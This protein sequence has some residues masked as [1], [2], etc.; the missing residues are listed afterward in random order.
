VADYLNENYMKNKDIHE[1]LLDEGVDPLTT[2]MTEKGEYYLSDIL[3]KHLTEQLRQP[4]VV[5]RSELLP[6]GHKQVELVRHAAKCKDCGTVFETK[7]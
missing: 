5:G 2:V 4:P 7:W 1:W 3:E 6:C